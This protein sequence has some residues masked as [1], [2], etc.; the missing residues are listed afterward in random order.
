MRAAGPLP[1]AGFIFISAI[2]KWRPDRRELAEFFDINIAVR[3]RLRLP[4]TG[5]LG[6]SYENAV[7]SRS[8]AAAAATNALAP[9]PAPLEARSTSDDEPAPSSG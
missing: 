4:V 8:V 1:S 9:L 6:S 5:I 7:S 2:Q 3:N